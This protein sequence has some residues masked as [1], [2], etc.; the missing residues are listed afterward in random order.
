M[1]K[2]CLP[3]LLLLQVWLQLA[4]AHSTVKYLPGFKGPL[5]FHLETG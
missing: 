5:P 3:F 4:A 1:A 2:Q